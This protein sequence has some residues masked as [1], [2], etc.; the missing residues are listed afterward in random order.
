M[1]NCQYFKMLYLRKKK[2]K[3]KRKEI[4]KQSN[5]MV[6]FQSRKLLLL[7][8]RVPFWRRFYYIPKEMVPFLS[9]KFCRFKESFFSF[10]H[11]E[12][13]GLLHRSLKVRCI[14]FFSFHKVTSYRSLKSRQFVQCEFLRTLGHWTNKGRKWP[15]IGSF[16]SWNY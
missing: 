15:L 1:K 7:Q 2:E 5:W 14:I 3:K 10:Y 16:V 12:D 6:S 11:L 4:G 9:R 13:R 8:R